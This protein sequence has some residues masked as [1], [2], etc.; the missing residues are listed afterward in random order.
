MNSEK[1]GMNSEF[2]CKLNA[3]HWAVLL[4][5]GTKATPGMVLQIVLQ[6]P[7]SKLKDKIFKHLS[8][9]FVTTLV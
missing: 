7:A 6:G 9:N 2:P 5:A 8:G 1:L 4:G 3:P